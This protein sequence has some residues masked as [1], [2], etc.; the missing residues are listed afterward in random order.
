MFVVNLAISDLGMMTTQA[1]NNWGNFYI[2]RVLNESVRQSSLCPFFTFFQIK[3]K[4]ENISYRANRDP[5]LSI[6]NENFE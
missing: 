5:H 3:M 2:V 6:Y 1:W 4:R